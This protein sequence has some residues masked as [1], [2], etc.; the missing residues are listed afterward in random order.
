MFR[1]LPAATPGS[2]NADPRSG[3]LSESRT[4]PQVP[5]ARRSST[6]SPSRRSPDP[7]DVIVKIGGAGVC[8]TD[9]HIIEGQWDSRD[10]HPA[11]VHPRP[12]ERRL[13]ARGRLRGHQRRGRRHGDPAPDA[14]LRAVPR[15]PGGRRHAL[16]EL[17]AS[18]ACPPTAGWPSTCSPAPAPASSS[19]R[20][21]S[22][23][24]SPR[25]PTPGITAYHAVRKALPLL[26]PGHHRGGHRGGRP[27]PHRR[28]V[29]GRAVRDAD[30]RRRPQP[31]RAQARRA[32]RR[33]RTPWSPTASR[34]TRCKDLTGGQ[35]A[36]V[37]L[38]FVAEQGAEMDAWNMTAP[39]GSV[40]R[41][42][43]RRHDA[44]SRP[45]T[46]SPPSATSSATSSAPTTS[47]PS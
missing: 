30:H 19:T 13:G 17:H 5:R 2:A 45:W 27:R 21:P 22:R 33:R 1:P 41:D 14:D 43:L 46:S 35:G 20:R 28:P 39:A 31:R 16:R 44:R 37:V 26:Y 34:S 25:W 40:L 24:T 23:R 18:R 32:A 15:L 42:R 29:P 8:R 10:G 3:G 9:L 7:L 6:R 12:R 11:A 4:N 47:S 38:D 36:H